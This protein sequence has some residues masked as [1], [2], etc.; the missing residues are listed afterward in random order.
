[1]RFIT[2][3]FLAWLPLLGLQSGLPMM[4]SAVDFEERGFPILFWDQPEDGLEY[5]IYAIDEAGARYFCGITQDDCYTLEVDFQA[6]EV[7]AV[8][9][10]VPLASARVLLNPQ[11][12]DNYPKLT[13][14]EWLQ[15][16]PYLLPNTHPAKENLDKLFQKERYSSSIS[17]LI[18]GGFEVKGPRSKGT[19]VAKHKDLPGILLKIFPDTHKGNDLKNFMN[20]INGAQLAKDI[21]SKYQ[22]EWLFKVPKKW[23]YILPQEP[24]PTKHSPKNLVLIVEDMELLAAQENYLEWKSDAITE[25][26]LD[27]IYIL[28][29]EGG[30]KDL[31]LAFNL[32]FSRDGL[33]AVVDTEDF[34]KSL[35]HYG[36]LKRFLSDEMVKYWNELV[37]NGGP[38][39]L[40]PK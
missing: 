39:D 37:A 40:L 27:A 26:K 6:F 3:L 21:I 36:R 22:F 32:P 8:K 11:Y 10:G 14:D 1:M 9:E 4:W 2:F 13:Q 24:L 15:I 20:R 28:L 12:K 31:T 16:A 17:T 33:L 18:K 7:D 30:F 35:I 23:I 19:L 25:K 29:T 5:H 34:H 38:S